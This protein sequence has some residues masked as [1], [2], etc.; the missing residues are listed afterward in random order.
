MN[1]V[2]FRNVYIVALEWSN[3]FLF[4]KTLMYTVTKGNH[5]E[6]NIIDLIDLLFS[7]WMK[8]ALFWLR[9]EII[10]QGTISITFSHDSHCYNWLWPAVKT[11]KN[12]VPKQARYSCINDCCLI[13]WKKRKMKSCKNRLFLFCG[14]PWQN[15]SSVRSWKSLF[16]T[17]NLNYYDE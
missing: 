7:E 12:T 2:I 5:L 15:V 3:H 17:K 1:H 16:K 14:L 9:V 6:W 13:S 8:Y 10:S 4:T 11:Q